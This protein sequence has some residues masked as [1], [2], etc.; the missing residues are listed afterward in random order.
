MEVY[1]DY[2]T[3]AWDPPESDGGEPIIA[4]EIEKS[5]GGAMYVSAAR[6]EATVSTVPRY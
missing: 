2:V 6:C 4:Y 5:L 1:K 3:I